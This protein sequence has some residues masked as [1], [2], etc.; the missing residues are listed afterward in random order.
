MPESS[1][2]QIQIDQS[3]IR[4][5][6]YLAR[7]IP[8]LTRSQIKKLI[9]QNDVLVDG[10]PA[11]WQGVNFVGLK[12]DGTPQDVRAKVKKTF[13]IICRSN[14]NTSQ[15]LERIRAEFDSCPEIDRLIEFIESSSRGVCK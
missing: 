8:Y 4:L 5:D 15:A 6:Q 11:K 2:V 3:D 12:R 1:K 9:Q 7:T 14:L 10:H 13:K